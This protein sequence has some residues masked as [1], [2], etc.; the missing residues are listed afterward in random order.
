MR[1]LTLHQPYA[2]AMALG[3]K[4]IETR[5]WSTA[6]RGPVVIHA[7]LAT[8]PEQRG[9]WTAIHAEDRPVF[10]KAGY[11]FLKALPLM[12]PVAVGNL[13]DCVPVETFTAPAQGIITGRAFRTPSG[14]L[15][16]L[17]DLERRW[18]D[19]TPGRFAWI[20]LNVTRLDHSRLVTGYQGL[21][22]Y[23]HGDITP[24]PVTSVPYSGNPKSQAA[25]S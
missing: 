2:T 3:L 8:G 10:A 9:Y 16:A 13:I 6:Y 12:Q 21:W 7:A 25:K 14:D 20:F 11:H 1:A 18:G 19:Y 4:R 15:L 23:R 5:S 24:P 17:T 22:H